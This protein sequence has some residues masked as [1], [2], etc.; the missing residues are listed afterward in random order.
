MKLST[1]E[2]FK[3]LSTTSSKKLISLSQ[4]QLQQL[5]KTVLQIADDI[6]NIC[7]DNNLNYHLTGGTALG[8]VRHNGFIPWDDDLDI[9]VARK[10]C[11]RLIELIKEKYPDKYYV[12]YAQN[13]EGYS[14]PSIQIRMKNTVVRGCNDANPEQCGAYIDVAIIENTFDNKVLRNIHGFISMGLGFIVSCRKFTKN[15]K[16][17]LSLVEN[18]KEATK[19]FKTKIRIGYIFSFLT[20]RRWT[21]IYDFWNRI[22]RNESTKY[23]TVPTGR[24]HFFGEIY[25][26]KDFYETTRHEFENRNWR[27]PKSYDKYLSHMY[28][29]YMKIPDKNHIEKHVLLEFKLLG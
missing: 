16:Y 17:L 28:G 4:E 25:E 22:C 13:K 26:R 20:L 2:V 1:T 5:Q 10:D 12:H 18:N 19:V 3:N 23:V 27:I 14:I 9:D 21:I 11:K 7:E 24:N 15:R 29:D 6:I 8:A